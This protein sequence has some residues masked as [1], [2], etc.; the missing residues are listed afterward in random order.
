VEPVREWPP[1]EPALALTD[2]Q[3]REAQL[4]F[5]SASIIGTLLDISDLEQLIP[6]I[7]GMTAE[8]VQKIC[9]EIMALEARKNE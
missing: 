2:E 5:E 9:E 1:Q 7:P 3:I 8:R 4:R 6:G